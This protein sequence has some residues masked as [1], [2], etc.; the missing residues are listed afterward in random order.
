VV[1][2]LELSG[3]AAPHVRRE[4]SAIHCPFDSFSYRWEAVGAQ[5]RA[6]VSREDGRIRIKVAREWASD[7]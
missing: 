2:A 3:R 5:G 6:C 1:E 7:R 4:W